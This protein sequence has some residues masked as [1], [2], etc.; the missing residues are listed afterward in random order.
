MTDTVLQDVVQYKHEIMKA[1]KNDKAL[2]SLLADVPDIDMDSDVAYDIM[3][4]NF[5]DY[6]F[7]DNTFQSDKAVVFVEVS[8]AR[9]PSVQFKSMK[10]QIQVLCNKGFAK[11]DGKKFRGMIGNRRDNIA[12]VIADILDRAD[13]FGVGELLLT[14]C[15]P[16]GTPVGFTGLGMVFTAVDFAGIEGYD[17]D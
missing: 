17:E 4:N 5:Y 2:I 16:T 9:R 1:L 10:V 6:S 7:S 3:D 8:M 13:E 14:T 12:V 15:E 11:L